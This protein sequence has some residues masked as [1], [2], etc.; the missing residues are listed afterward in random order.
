MPIVKFLHEDQKFDFNQVDAEED[1]A[2]ILAIEQNFFEIVKYLVEVCKVDLERQNL[3]GRTA[4]HVACRENR[5]EM[6]S[7]LIDKGANVYHRSKTGKIILHNACYDGYT[8]LV[9]L[10]L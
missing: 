7:Y 4:L 3:N 1:A 5:I 6:V 2:I 8:D 9:E 10:I